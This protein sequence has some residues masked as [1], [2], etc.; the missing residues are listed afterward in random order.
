MSI[1]ILALALVCLATMLAKRWSD[2]SPPMQP[3]SPVAD[4]RRPHRLTVSQ[5]GRCG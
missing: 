2:L 5:R 1:L 3:A 4:R